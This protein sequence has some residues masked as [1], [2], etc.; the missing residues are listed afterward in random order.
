[1]AEPL[2]FDEFVLSVP[3]DGLSLSV[4]SYLFLAD[5]FEPKLDLTG[6]YDYVKSGQLWILPSTVSL[7]IVVCIE[8]AALIEDDSCD[9]ILEF[10]TEKICQS[11]LW[12]SLGLSA[13]CT[14]FTYETNDDE[15][16]NIYL[17]VDH[18]DKAASLLSPPEALTTSI[19]GV[20]CH[21]NY[22]PIAQSR[23]YRQ[24]QSQS[25]RSAERDIHRSTVSQSQFVSDQTSNRD[26]ARMQAD[27]WP[28]D[29]DEVD[30]MSHR[31][32]TCTAQLVVAALYRIIG[33]RPRFTGV[34]GITPA[35]PALL[36]VAP[37][38][39]NAH[40]MQLTRLHSQQIPV[41]SN[42]IENAATW[43]LTLQEKIANISKGS[44]DEL[45]L[46]DETDPDL[47]HKS[48]QRHLWTLLR[49][50]LSTKI[51][52]TAAAKKAHTF[53]GATA[54]GLEPQRFSD[55][56]SLMVYEDEVG[57]LVDYD[58]DDTEYN[59]SQVPE[60]WSFENSMREHG[61]AGAEIDCSSEFTGHYADDGGYAD[62]EYIHG[63]GDEAITP[64]GDINPEHPYT[65]PYLQSGFFKRSQEVYMEGYT[66]SY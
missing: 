23:Q 60:H 21:L 8:G 54:D 9:N 63:T 43:R 18:P 3:S 12:N 42:I 36:D 7:Q 30:K 10:L 22:R 57:E 56:A 31:R 17:E 13:T 50:N 33:I 4:A 49:S 14:K 55:D 58:N 24:N 64:Y 27:S 38:M 39:W 51:Q 35:S 19:E 59:E 20:V 34:Q 5:D 6:V 40:Y 15:P 16:A 44:G 53:L 26:D 45:P 62:K 41:I 46:S 11:P 28:D 1:M 61:L 29:P 66:G 52:I 37:S 48:L 2:V 32:R 65:R 25:R 47:Q